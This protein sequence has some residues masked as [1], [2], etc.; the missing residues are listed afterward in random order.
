[1]YY[2][3]NTIRKK[4]S[5]KLKKKL[6][7]LKRIKMFH[8]YKAKAIIRWSVKQK[9]W[10][11][12]RERVLLRDEGKCRWCG[13]GWNTE[14]HHIIPKSRGGTDEERNLLTLCQLHHTTGKDAVHNGN[15]DLYMAD[16]Q[17]IIRGIYNDR[18]GEVANGKDSGG[19]N[20]R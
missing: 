16:F 19:Y 7:I 4:I 1:M 2:P 11:D 5:K 12:I 3:K 15:V 10:N 13:S 20:G 18:K 8:K 14:V 6:L 9:L 17:K